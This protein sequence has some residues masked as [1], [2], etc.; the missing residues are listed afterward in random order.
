[1]IITTDDGE[2]FDPTHLLEEGL[3]NGFPVKGQTFDEIVANQSAATPS[4]ARHGKGRMT[5][6]HPMEQDIWIP[7]Q[8]KGPNG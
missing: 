7:G 5:F 1:M 2:H 6:E 3:Q 8:G 4:E